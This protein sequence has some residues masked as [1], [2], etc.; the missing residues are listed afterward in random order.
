MM[1]KHKER[2]RN[3]VLMGFMGC[4]KTTVGRSLSYRLQ[5]AVEDTDHIIEE[6][7]GKTI[8]EIFAQQGEN[9]FRKMETELLVKLRDGASRKIYSL[10][11]GTPIQ[12]QNQALIRQIGFV[13]W[14]RTTPETVYERVKND[15]ARPLLQCE[16]PM[17]RIRE[18]LDRRS[19]VYERCADLI[20]DTDDLTR[21][22]VT[23]TIAR[24]YES[25]LAGG[26]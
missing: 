23:E 5:M 14:L 3:L 15:T 19:P 12:L 4:G 9:A 10:G 8:S 26:E 21:E 13:V 2:N 22:E 20:I 1:T 25:F 11:G 6:M 16:D 18:L 17:G 7:E 24:A